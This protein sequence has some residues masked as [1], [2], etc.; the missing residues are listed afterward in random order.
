MPQRW[1][2]CQQLFSGT[3]RSGEN[4]QYTKACGA[5]ISVKGETAF[6]MMLYGEE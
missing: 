6:V 4:W 2:W 5:L 3:D 1:R